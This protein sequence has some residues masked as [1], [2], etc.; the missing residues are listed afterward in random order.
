MTRLLLPALLALLLAAPASAAAASPVPG[1]IAPPEGNAPFLQGHAVGVQI[2][3]CNGT[4]WSL[5]APRA[6]LFD[7]HGNLIATHFAG[8][9]W[10]TKDGSTVVGSRVAAVK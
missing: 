10:Q 5:V 7:R 4:S 2:Y 9:T 1:D 3:G 8:P 6:D